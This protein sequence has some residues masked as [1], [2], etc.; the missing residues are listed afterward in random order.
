MSIHVFILS[1]RK[2]Y[3]YTTIDLEFY[4]KERKRKMSFW[5][6]VV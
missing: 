2:L 6:C 3:N 5:L 1:V 4:T